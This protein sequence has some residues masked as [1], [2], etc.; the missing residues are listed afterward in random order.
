MSERAWSDEERAFAV[1]SFSFSEFSRAFPGRTKDGW[2]IK[3]NRMIAGTVPL[4]GHERMGRPPRI[5]A[6]ALIEPRAEPEPIRI[7]RQSHPKGWEPGISWDGKRGEVTSPPTTEAAPDWTAVLEHFNLDPLLY[8]VLEPVQMRTWDAVLK[9]EVIQHWYYKANFVKRRSGGV[10]LEAL[11]VEVRAHRP[12]GPRP[13]AGE[14]AYFV[15]FNDW[16]LGKEGTVAAVERIQR[17]IDG[18]VDRLADLRSIGRSIGTVYILGLGDMIE[19]CD[20]H[21]AMQRFT[22]ELNSREQ[23]RLT[24][25]LIMHGIER[26]APLA[27]R[28][29][30]PVVGGNHGENNRSGG[31]VTT[32]FSD[33]SDLEVF[34]GVAE[35]CACNPDAYGHVSF[36]IAEKQLTLTLQPITGGPIV[37]MA[38][39]HQ[40]KRGATAQQRVA[41]WWSGQAFGQRPVGDATILVTAHAHHFSVIENG[42]RTHLL[43]P[44]LDSG[45]QWWEESAGIPTTQGMLT[46]VVDQAGWTDLQVIR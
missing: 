40:A 30:V 8:E 36:V 32:S 10:D 4:Q 43:A 6:A 24:R 19:S 11:L 2:R 38:H 23:R 33:N 9:G 41:T 20:E 25:R 27:D 15:C 44:T 34:E 46:F 18:A 1:R 26:F 3:R 16:Q 37:G 29:V 42:P 45:S 39:G 13:Q 7:V 35:A 28:V 17:F 31:K 14:A 21:Y 12:S 5:E 22:V